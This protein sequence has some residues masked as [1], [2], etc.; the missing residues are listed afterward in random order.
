MLVPY[1][2]ILS[3]KEKLNYKKL[4]L[5]TF[6]IGFLIIIL[7]EGIIRLIDQD[8]KE[9]LLIFVAPLITFVCL[10]SITY[11]LN[12]KKNLNESIH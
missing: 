4:K 2:L 1:L 3:S 8:L 7:S 12:F 10:F 5:I 9:N 6:L 11:K